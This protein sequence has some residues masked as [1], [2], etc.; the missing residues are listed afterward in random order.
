V[1]L[2]PPT[3]PLGKRLAVSGSGGDREDERERTADNVSLGLFSWHRNWG[4]WISSRMSP[5]GV[6]FTGR[7]VPGIE[8][9]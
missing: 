8:A 6:L 4:S 9:A 3:R 1:R 2:P 5:A 7:M